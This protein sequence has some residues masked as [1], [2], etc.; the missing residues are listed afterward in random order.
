MH[1]VSS[2]GS[3]PALFTQVPDNHSLQSL[4]S[5]LAHAESVC[6]R[7]QPEVA[8]WPTWKCSQQVHSGVHRPVGP[9][10]ATF[11]KNSKNHASLCLKVLQHVAVERALPA[12]CMGLNI[13][14]SYTVLNTVSGES[15]NKSFAHCNA[16]PLPL[17][18]IFIEI[19]D[20]VRTSSC[21]ECKPNMYV[22]L[23]LSISVSNHLCT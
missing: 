19:R 21:Q 22:S 5:L 20:E 1:F 3:S 6:H 10:R 23:Q 4:L 8:L 14:R 13:S 12:Y 16:A 18:H 11:T 17:C 7:E 15:T 2:S 9:K